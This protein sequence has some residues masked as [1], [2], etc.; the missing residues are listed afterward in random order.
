M[1]IEAQLNDVI[2]VNINHN[3]LHYRYWITLYMKPGEIILG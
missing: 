1:F 3:F 2:H